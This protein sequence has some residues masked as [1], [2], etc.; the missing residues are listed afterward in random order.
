MAPEEKLGRLSHLRERRRFIGAGAPARRNG[1]IENSQINAELAAVLIPVIEHDVA[2]KLR[3]GHGQYFLVALNHAPDLMELSVVHL[4]QQISD[5][6][7][8]FFKFGQ[9]FLFGCR[10]GKA[11]KIR[12]RRRT[13]L[14]E[15]NYAAGHKSEVISELSC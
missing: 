15:L 11:G 6:G 2:D 10:L 5:G 13:V 1:H 4:R 8:A 12:S 14:Y 9:N 7:H 3:A